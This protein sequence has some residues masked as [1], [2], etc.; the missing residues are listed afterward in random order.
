MD[1]FTGKITRVKLNDKY[2]ESAEKLGK[3]GWT[4]PM[5]LPVHTTNE[6]CDKPDKIDEIMADYYGN[7]I[8]FTNMVGELIAS[9]IA[10]SHRSIILQSYCAYKANLYSICMSSLNPLYEGFLSNLTEDKKNV[11]IKKILQ[12]I[13]SKCFDNTNGSLINQSIE[14]IYFNL[15]AFF[16]EYTKST[17]FTGMQKEY[18]RNGIAHGRIN[19]NDDQLQ[20]IK[21][22]S[23][24][25]NIAIFFSDLIN[26]NGI[27]QNGI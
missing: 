22:F 23:N 5:D 1:N 9:K 3:S 6:I 12:E 24:L 16:D 10:K 27:I 14:L 2:K 25:Y 18:N 11:S 4:I 19:I 26:E 15:N 20:V 7:D 8:R 21:M 17:P 13:K